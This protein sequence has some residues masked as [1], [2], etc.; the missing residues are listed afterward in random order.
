MMTVPMYLFSLRS[1]CRKSFRVGVRNVMS[2]PNLPSGRPLDL[3]SSLISPNIYLIAY[4]YVVRLVGVFDNELAVSSSR[5]HV[6]THWS[7]RNRIQEIVVV[8]VIVGCVVLVLVPAV[9]RRGRGGA[10]LPSGHDRRRH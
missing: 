5:Y 6:A 3:F 7:A 4:L 1:S 2:W 9:G 10:Q 8:G